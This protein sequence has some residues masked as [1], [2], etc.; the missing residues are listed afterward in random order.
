MKKTINAL[1]ARFPDADIVEIRLDK[2]SDEDSRKLIA[3]R[4]ARFTEAIL[5]AEEFEFGNL[6]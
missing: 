1:K 4:E 3:A 2:L 5:T 6:H